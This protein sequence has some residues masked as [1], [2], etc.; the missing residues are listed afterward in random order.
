MSARRGR[1][2]ASTGNGG[3]RVSTE[4][5]GFERVPGRQKSRRVPKM[6]NPGKYRKCGIQVST[7]KVG[8]GQ[9]PER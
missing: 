4:N 9:V 6:G 2:R 5:V 1:I 7:G 8:S 3:I